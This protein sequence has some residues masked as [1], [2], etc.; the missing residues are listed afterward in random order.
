MYTYIYFFLCICTKTN[1]LVL[2]KN[3][4]K[5][6]MEDSLALSSPLPPLK[7]TVN[8]ADPLRNLLAI[9][10]ENRKQPSVQAVRNLNETHFIL[11]IAWRKLWMER[12]GSHGGIQ[13]LSLS[14]LHRKVKGESDELAIDEMRL[15]SVVPDWTQMVEVVRMLCKRGVLRFH[16]I[17]SCDDD[18]QVKLHVTMSDKAGEDMLNSINAALMDQTEVLQEQQQESITESGKKRKRPNGRF[19]PRKKVYSIPLCILE[20]H[21]EY[22]RRDLVAETERYH[23]QK[24]KK[25]G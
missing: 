20:L 15:C 22:E 13:S 10:A 8:T 24:K 25:V 21:L 6:P 14:D 4:F 11:Y 7:G 17:I 1:C 2:H 12:M 18:D 9:T 19:Q 3:N 16:K 5:N 23:T